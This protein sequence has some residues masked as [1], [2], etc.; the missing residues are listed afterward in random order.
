M[1]GLLGRLL[2]KPRDNQKGTGKT[3]YE[4]VVKVKQRTLTLQGN[5]EKG[6]ICDGSIKVL[7]CARREIA[8]EGRRQW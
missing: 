7:L 5:A 2:K 8:V 3:K 1:E 6:A 4:M